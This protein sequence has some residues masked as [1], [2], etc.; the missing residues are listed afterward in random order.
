MPQNSNSQDS[1][2][3]LGFNY[4]V[5]FNGQYLSTLDM[6][7]GPVTDF[8]T[9]IA[10]MLSK[11]ILLENVNPASG[12][13]T[14]EF[15]NTLNQFANRAV[16]PGTVVLLNKLVIN[17]GFIKVG[18]STFY[19]PTMR[20]TQEP[21]VYPTDF[22]TQAP[23]TPAIDNGFSLAG[24]FAF[25]MSFSL[26]VFCYLQ[27]CPG[28]IPGYDHCI[29]NSN[30]QPKIDKSEHAGLQ[31]EL[32][33]PIDFEDLSEPDIRFGK[34]HAVKRASLLFDQT[35][36]SLHLSGAFLSS[37]GTQGTAVMSMAQEMS[38]A[39]SGGRRFVRSFILS[40]F[41]LGAAAL[42]A[43]LSLPSS[44][45]RCFSLFSLPLPSLPLSQ[46]PINTDLAP[47]VAALRCPRPRCPRRRPR[48]TTTT[49][50][51]AA[52]AFPQAAPSPRAWTQSPPIPF[53]ATAPCRHRRPPRSQ[54]PTPQRQRQQRPGPAPAPGSALRTWQR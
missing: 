49:T 22:P 11:Q 25:L 8:N 52:V 26:F 28:W 10:Y 39:S 5:E 43:L 51:A 12:G 54:T 6:G 29:G 13:S 17:D 45:T 30:N 27:Y 33:R 47:P 41:I 34:G 31:V 2:P 23:I 38:G 36:Q 35:Q 40:L 46:S 50:T 15:Q 16:N 42:S 4:T 3:I 48:A 1:F 37:G 24:G 14:S 44:H 7:D 9:R 20:P 21:T 19:F 53:T 18:R 32:G